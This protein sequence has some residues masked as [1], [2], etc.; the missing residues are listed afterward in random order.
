MKSIAPESRALEK[1]DRQ[2]VFSTRKQSLS[3]FLYAFI[4]LLEIQAGWVSIF[5]DFDIKV[6]IGVNVGLLCEDI[7]RLRSRLETLLTSEAVPSCHEE[8]ERNFESAAALREYGPASDFVIAI[9]EDIELNAQS[10]LEDPDLEVVDQ[11]TFLILKEMLLSIASQKKL[12]QPWHTQSCAIVKIQGL[13]DERVHV[14]SAQENV[15]EDRPVLPARPSKWTYSTESIMR[16]KSEAELAELGE[17]LRRFLHFIIVD[18][19][20]N[21]LE[22]C[23]RNIVEFR[24]MPLAFKL[25]MGRQIW[26]E[27]RHAIVFKNLLEEIGGFLGEYTYNSIVW[28]RHYMGE[29]LAER[30]AIQQVLQEGNA[31]EENVAL[32]R[33]FREH[34]HMKFANALDYVNADEAWH[35]HF[36]NRWLLRLTDGS[37]NAY[38]RQMEMAAARLNRPI[39]SSVQVNPELRKIAAFPA[40]YVE[41]LERQKNSVSKD[42]DET[43]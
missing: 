17:A 36:G 12:M 2:N 20:I 26:D 35:A 32:T 9:L 42:T 31:L 29:S 8:Y 30:L 11:P 34:G 10:L 39:F 14:Y 5:P 40:W 21:A 15:A 33:V 13:G 24:S 7:R 27:A 4:R 3:S 22:V 28:R 25:D 23:G 38:F 16:H 41:E 18:I 1:P 19:E 37:K 43:L 6:A